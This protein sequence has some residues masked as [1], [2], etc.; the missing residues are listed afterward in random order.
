M[1]EAEIR[2]RGKES[3]DLKDYRVSRTGALVGRLEDD[4]QLIVSPSEQWIVL[5]DLDA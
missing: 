3:F 5:G 2:I 4:R 1:T